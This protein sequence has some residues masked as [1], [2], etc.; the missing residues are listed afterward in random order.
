[1]ADT[2]AAALAER[3]YTAITFDFAGFG[4]SGGGPRQVELPNRKIADII[5]AAR[6][7]M[8]ELSWLPFL[9]FDGMSRASAVTAPTLFV[10]SDGCVFPDNIRRLRREL[11]GPVEVAWGAGA[12]IDFYDQPGQVRFAVDAVGAHFSATIGGV[13][14]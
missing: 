12:Q 10:H 3:G 8:A 1:M 9:T 6:N 14:A 7:E 5:A 13:P 2:Y 4:R 11:R